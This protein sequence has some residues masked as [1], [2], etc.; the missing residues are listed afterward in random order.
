MSQREYAG[1]LARNMSLHQNQLVLSAMMVYMIVIVV[2]W[3]DRCA[4]HTYVQ[5]MHSIYS[6]VD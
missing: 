2:Y 6:T 1:G 4:M 5:Y 3:F